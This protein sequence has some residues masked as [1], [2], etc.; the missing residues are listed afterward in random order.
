[1]SD[2]NDLPEA[3]G[4]QEEDGEEDEDHQQGDHNS[5]DGGHGNGVSRE[6]KRG[7]LKKSLQNLFV[8]LLNVSCLMRAYSIHSLTYICF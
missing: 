7:C 4:H 3:V 8:V 2:Q 5:D 6:I 1:M